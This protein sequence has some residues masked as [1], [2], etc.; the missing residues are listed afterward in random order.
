MAHSIAFTYFIIK[1][2]TFVIERSP[3][4]LKTPATMAADALDRTLILYAA[5]MESHTIHPVTPDVIGKHR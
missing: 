2:E 4:L 3:C 5:W 1:N